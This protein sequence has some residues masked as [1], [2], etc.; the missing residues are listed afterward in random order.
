MSRD[1]E[2]TH[3]QE[4][5]IS[6]KPSVSMSDP[7]ATALQTVIAKIKARLA[8]AT[9]GPWRISMTGY[10]VKSNSD[11]MPIVAQNP[12]GVAMREINIPRWLDN[13]EFMAHAPEDIATLLNALEALLSSPAQEEKPPLIAIEILAADTLPFTGW[14]L[15]HDAPRDGTPFRAYAPWLI[16]E[17]FNP[18]GT[19]EAVF[20]GND[21]FIGA[22]WDGQHD[23][24]NTQAI[25][26]AMWQ[27]L[28]APVPASV[29]QEPR[30]RE[31]LTNAIDALDAR[32]NPP[33][34]IC[35]EAL[36]YTRE[37]LQLLNGATDAH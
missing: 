20:D 4:H 8:K 1:E 14:M 22:I 18:T 25:T 37:A 13:A 10:S 36:R 31:L 28:T 12:W 7:Q 17:D 19:V 23:C 15:A 21:G 26:F 32:D 34:D 24:W 9:P 30:I 6:S 16:D 3:E 11:D 29:A 27:P 5:A 33:H 35:D 2:L